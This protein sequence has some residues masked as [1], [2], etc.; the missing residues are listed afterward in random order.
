METLIN[1]TQFLYKLRITVS[2]GIN[3]QPVKMLTLRL[4]VI[5][6]LEIIYIPY[7][8]L[9]ILDLDEFAISTVI[10]EANI[11]HQLLE[12]INAERSFDTILLLHQGIYNND[13]D[14]I[15]RYPKPKIFLNRNSEL[16]YKKNYNSE[17]LLVVIISQ[18]EDLEVIDVVAHTLDFMRQSRSLLIAVDVIQHADFLEASLKLFQKYKMTNVLL[19]FVS[20]QGNRTRSYYQ[21]KPYPI[22]HW[23]NNSMACNNGT[24]FPQHWRNM[25]LGNIVTYPNQ[26]LPNNLVY[27]DDQGNVKFNG[28]VARL[29]L[30]FAELF[31]ATLRMYK[32]LRVGEAIHFTLVNQL[33]DDNLVDIPM[34]LDISDSDSPK[35]IYRTQVYYIGQGMLIVP[36]AQP[37]TNK[38]VFGALLD[39]YF[40][41]S[42]LICLVVFALVIYLIRYILDKSDT[43]YRMVLNF[44]LLPG[45]LGQSFVS[46]KSS[47]RSL[48]LVYILVLFAG[49][50]INIQ[51]MANMNTLFTSHPFHKQIETLQ[52]IKNSDLK[53]NILKSDSELMG[54]I[55]LPIIRS[56]IFSSNVTEYKQNIHNFNMSTGYFI[57]SA[58]LKYL[59]K[60]QKR[61]SHKAFFC[62]FE[63]MTVF[64]FLPWTVLLQQHSQ[65]KEP[66]DYLINRVHDLGL[67]DAWHAST[68][69][70]LLKLNRLASFQDS[71]VQ[72]EPQAMTVDDLHWAWMISA[73]GL[74]VGV[75]MFIVELWCYHYYTEIFN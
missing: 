57:D 2:Y 69:N 7:N 53:I 72:Q 24:Y 65:Y 19:Q 36:C 70:E 56:L 55:L 37:L 43:S 44:N 39:I 48:K 13:L 45:V 46:P 22:Y 23:N 42:I 33:V 35:W 67:M 41:G 10:D 31:N 66:M 4:V 58:D 73:I 29:V 28:F 18:T 63:N 17:I 71:S 11:Y 52:D 75:V 59:Q 40:F 27:E 51:F 9:K 21:L 14:A 5:I 64:R 54:G 8:Y 68:Y 25:N 62:T 49:L 26:D 38:E 6:V 15:Y 50:N 34:N 61:M 47:W 1:V 30:L 32:P 20:S 60:Q 3:Q 74:A 16:S 12:D